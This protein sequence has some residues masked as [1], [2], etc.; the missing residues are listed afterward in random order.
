[1][2]ISLIAEA[3]EAHVSGSSHFQRTRFVFLCRAR[4]GISELYVSR[5]VFV[6]LWATDALSVKCRV[7]RVREIS[8]C[9]IGLS[10]ASPVPKP[11]LLSL[12]P[13]S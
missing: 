12:L 2:V 3:P 13:V 1:M 5:Q 8:R 4:T 10:L 9:P 11:P 7:R 6:P